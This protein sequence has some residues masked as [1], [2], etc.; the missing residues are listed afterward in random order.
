MKVRRHSKIFELI[1]EHSISTQEELQSFLKQSGFNV[2]QATVSR[3][4]KELRLGKTLDAGGNYFY[5]I[6]SSESSSNNE[7]FITIFK[8]SVVSISVCGNLLVVKC[9]IGMGNAACAALDSMGYD[10]VVGTIAGDDTIFV[11]VKNETIGEQLLNK[12][13]LEMLGK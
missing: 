12:L 2:T 9:M 10:E 4:I 1:K 7:K 3:D 13:N 8:E 11:A 6:T 5:R